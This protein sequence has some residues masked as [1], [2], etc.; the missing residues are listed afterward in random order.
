METPEEEIDDVRAILIQ[1]MEQA[2]QL[3]VPL[4]AEVQEG[5][6]WYEAH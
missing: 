6:S 1:E 5:R 4:L 2:A 3:K